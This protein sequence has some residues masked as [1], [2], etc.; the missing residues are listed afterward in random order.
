MGIMGIM[1]I[2]FQRKAYMGGGGGGHIKQA[3]SPQSILLL[4]NP[5]GWS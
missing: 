2:M 3:K 4:H 5:I 1:G